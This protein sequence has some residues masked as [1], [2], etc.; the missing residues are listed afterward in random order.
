MIK[1]N[2][3]KKILVSILAFIAGLVVVKSQLKNNQPSIEPSP[4]PET[5]TEVQTANQEQAE[6]Q[7]QA[8]TQEQTEVQ[9]QAEAQQN[10]SYSLIATQSGQIALDLLQAKEKVET[11]DYGQMGQ[12]IISINGLTSD[13]GHFWAFYI[14]DE[15]SQVGASQAELKTD[16]VI[17]FVYEE[18]K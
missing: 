18:I 13:E 2:N 3:N 5:Q 4:T 11:K 6:A 16:D 1:S 10:A 14:N 7:E 15:Q 12:L 8:V 17:K 9:E